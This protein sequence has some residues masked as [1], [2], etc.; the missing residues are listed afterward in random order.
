MA[1]VV[2][3]APET[4]CDD[5]FR[6]VAALIKEQCG[7]NIV[8]G[9]KALL[10]GRLRKRIHALGF[11]SCSDYC[12]FLFSSSGR[13]QELAAMIDAITTNT[14][15]FFREPFSGKRFFALLSTIGFT[16][17]SRASVTSRRFNQ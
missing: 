9:K 5:D 14:T 16:L 12:D 17:Y 11:P 13:E 15:N 10:E 3:R 1:T 8:F 7:I 6:R 2:G 4:L